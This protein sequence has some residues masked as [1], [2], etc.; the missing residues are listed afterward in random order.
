M[1]RKTKTSCGET[2]Q[3]IFS[4]MTQ[5]GLLIA[6]IHY[7]TNS[8]TEG[9][10]FILSFIIYIIY[11]INS[12]LSPT[13][14]YLKHKHKANT[15][16]EY[17][18]T[19][20]TAAPRKT[21]NVEC[22]HNETRRNKTK[23]AKGKVKKET[24]SV[25]VVTYRGSQDFNYYSSKDISGTFLLETSKFLDKD[26]KK[27]YIKLKLDLEIDYAED[28]TYN[29]YAIQRDSFYASNRYRDLHM[30]TWESTNLKGLNEYNLVKVSGNK[31]PF[32][33]VTTYLV[34][35][36]LL[37]LVELYKMYINH[38]CEEQTY[39]IRKVISTR[40][41]LNLPTHSV[42]YDSMQPKLIIYGHEELVEQNAELVQSVP[43]IPTEE[44]IKAHEEE[45]N[46]KRD[47]VDQQG[48]D[49]NREDD[50]PSFDEVTGMK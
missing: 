44:E 31:A 16:H 40:K 22:Y 28:G 43:Y 39:T 26:F 9:S 18:N 38:Y 46:Y 13:F 10:T 14:F 3:K 42:I 12:F 36:V 15:I 41:N 6:L 11:V 37:P 27:S 20:Y 34:F 2:C 21:F 17:M 47:H 5:L 48:E 25:R 49:N 30:D 32:V 1:P 19:M 7:I 24:K 23:D 33:N 4:W 50:L 29:D 35:T 8:G 45:S